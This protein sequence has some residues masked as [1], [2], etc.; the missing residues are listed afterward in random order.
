MSHEAEEASD[1][2]SNLVCQTKIKLEVFGSYSRSNMCSSCDMPFLDCGS[3]ALCT[4]CSKF[5][6]QTHA[7]AAF[8]PYKARNASI[9]F[10]AFS[11]PLFIALLIVFGQP[12]GG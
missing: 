6:L 11:F 10:L 4:S 7:G 8:L 1:I 5:A 12:A 2:S 9:D 3:R